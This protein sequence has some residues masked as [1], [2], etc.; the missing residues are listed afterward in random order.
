MRSSSA[1]GP[2]CEPGLGSDFFLGNCCL[3]F[4]F[5]VPREW[6]WV[7]IDGNELLDHGAAEHVP[8]VAI[9]AAPLDKPAFGVGAIRLEDAV[10]SWV[11]A[12]DELAILDDEVAC[13]HYG[14]NCNDGGNSV[15][16]GVDFLA[17]AWYVQAVA[18]QETD[19]FATNLR[20]LIYFSH[21]T[22]R[23]AARALDVA[24]HTLSA[25]LTGKRKPGAA[26]LMAIDRIYHIS[27]RDLDLPPADF[28]QLLA[29]RER[30]AHAEENIR[31]YLGVGG[32]Q[33][34]M[35][36]LRRRKK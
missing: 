32:K 33:V 4:L 19:A 2:P 9:R 6:K 8:R 10:A 30:M 7:L 36:P 31:V 20:R 26:G 28:A 5:V 35:L 16:S 3:T 1:A 22:A 15:A 24:E 34:K 13:I 25:W 12:S 17:V 21:P 18:G 29:D 11:G 27:P 14:Q 23:E